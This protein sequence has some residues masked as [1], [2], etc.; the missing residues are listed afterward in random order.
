MAADPE[1]RRPGGRLRGQVV[2][3]PA[4]RE[5]LLRVARRG[6]GGHR[7]AAGIDRGRLAQVAGEVDLPD[8]VDGEGAPSVHGVEFRLGLGR[9]EDGPRS[10]HPICTTALGAIMPESIA[11]QYRRWGVDEL[12]HKYPDLRVIPF[13]E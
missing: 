5:E 3:R 13:M 10:P 8:R 11:E 9:C 4:A 12:L 6:P 1:S 7:E 2:P